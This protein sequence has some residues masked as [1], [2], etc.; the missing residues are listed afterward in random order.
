MEE[1]REGHVEMRL[2]FGPSQL[3]LVHHIRLPWWDKI[4]NYVH[5]Y[6]VWR[7]LCSCVP[8]RFFAVSKSVGWGRLLAC[9]GIPVQRQIYDLLRPGYFFT[10]GD[11]SNLSLFLHTGGARCQQRR[12]TQARAALLGSTYDSLNYTY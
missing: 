7:K 12:R 11:I 1:R 5:L 6:S 4:G 8:I 2:R 9:C 3:V 10:C